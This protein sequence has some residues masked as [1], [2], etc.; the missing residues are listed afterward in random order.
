M[1]SLASAIEESA[2]LLLHAGAVE[3]A[4]QA[5]LF[6]GESGVGK[7]TLTAACLIRGFG[8][9]TDEA[10]ALDPDT[11]RVTGLARPLMLTPWSTEA[12][13]LDPALGG[14]SDESADKLAFTAQSIGARA[15]TEP[16]AVGHVV[17]VRRSGARS[18]PVIEPVAAGEVLAAVLAAS[19]NHYRLG[20]RAW[21][22]AARLSTQVQGWRLDADEPVA[23]ADAILRLLPQRLEAPT[24]AVEASPA[25]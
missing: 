1:H 13:G 12:L 21:E 9:I 16:V 15:V 17:L 8:Y 14:W 3:R 10:V 2:D 6:P 24:T 5:V 19:F 7:S 22:A 23:A 25:L 20:E 18:N 11:G 4:G